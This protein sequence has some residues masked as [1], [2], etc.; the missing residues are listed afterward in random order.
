M[1]LVAGA[2]FMSY[3]LLDSGNDVTSVTR[4][5]QATT[6]AEA[7]TAAAAH[8]TALATVTN[9]K[10]VSYSVGQKYVENALT[11]F[12]DDTVRNSIQAV[13]TASIEDQPL[14]KATISIPAPKNAC[15]TAVTGEGSDVVD[16]GLTSVVTTFL[17]EFKDGGNVFISDGE[18]LDIITNAKGVRVSK[19]RRLA[20]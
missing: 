15:F 14:K 12:S 11:G 7:A 13:I 8:M 16:V 18:K 19:Y 2:W 10:V 6:A 1:A 9:A 3:E 20:K 5:L 4:R 17:E